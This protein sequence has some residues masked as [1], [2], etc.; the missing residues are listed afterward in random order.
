M[1]K[2][3]Q[4]KKN[5]SKSKIIEKNK[6]NNTYPSF[7]NDMKKAYALALYELSC[8]I[9]FHDDSCIQ[10]ES[11]GSKRVYQISDKLIMIYQPSKNKDDD[12]EIDHGN[13]LFIF[14]K[15][16]KLSKQTK[17]DIQKIKEEVDKI[18][19]QDFKDLMKITKNKWLKPLHKDYGVKELL[20]LFEELN[21]YDKNICKMKINI[22]N[23]YRY[24]LVNGWYP[25]E[26]S[27]LCNKFNKINHNED[28]SE[29]SFEYEV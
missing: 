7:E 28:L 1:T 25:I 14:N 26:I 21:Y 27:K 24:S 13:I 8:N 17:L 19:I 23:E 11:I 4:T 6:K 18:Y 29:Y 10:N 12:F 20:D 2:Q 9:R 15:S 16:V 3:K 5:N 22:M